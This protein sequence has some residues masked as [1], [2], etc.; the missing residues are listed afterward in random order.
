MPKSLKIPAYLNE[1]METAL[2]KTDTLAPASLGVSTPRISFKGK[3]FRL[4]QEGEEIEKIKDN[5]DC[6]IVG[7]NPVN[8]YAKT[9]YKGEWVDGEPSPPDCSSLNGVYPDSWV[10][11][12]Q[13]DKCIT[14]PMNKFGSKVG[15]NGKKAKAC[16]DSKHLYIVLAKDLKDAEDKNDIPYYLANVTISSMKPLVEYSTVL[17]DMGIS[18]P[19]V[20]ITRITFDEDTS[21]PKLNFEA[22]GVLTKERATISL[23]ISET[24]ND[25]IKSWENMDRPQLSQQ[26]PLKT[27]GKDV[28]DLLENFKDE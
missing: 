25:M 17:N 24:C 27:I 14:C 8:G 23:Q 10:S 5:L 2:V 19:S 28:D 3:I 22:I 9:F 15:L 18:S 6:I 1:M 13:N 21:F 26:E 16:R 11:E 12:P 7:I 20:V 4:N